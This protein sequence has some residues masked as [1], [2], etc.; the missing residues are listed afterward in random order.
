MEAD[1]IEAVIGLGANLFYNSPMEA[2]VV[3]LRSHKSSERQSK[4]LFI[5]GV[6][7]VTRERAYSSL[8]A[9]NLKKLLSA[10]FQPEEHSDVARLVELEEIRGNNHNLSVPLYTQGGNGHRRY[11]VSTAQQA[12][13]DSRIVLQDQT[14][15]LFKALQEVGYKA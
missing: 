6:Q 7:Q 15:A 1:L 2:C 13:Q 10:Y 8:S 12:W 14:D 11:D 4:I 9:A 3:V 5:E